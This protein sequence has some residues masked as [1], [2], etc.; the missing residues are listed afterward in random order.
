MI[1][2]ICRWHRLQREKQPPFPTCRSGCS[3]GTGGLWTYSCKPHCQ[4]W[5]ALP[6]EATQGVWQVVCECAV[7]QKAGEAGSLWV[8]WCEPVGGLC[9][10][11]LCA[12]HGGGWG[13][14]LG[15]IIKIMESYSIL[16]WKGPTKVTEPNCCMEKEALGP[17]V[18]IAECSIH[19]AM[20]TKTQW[21]VLRFSMSLSSQSCL[22]CFR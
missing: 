11:H 12:L 16:S 6:Q 8:S 15:R 14:A 2:I 4:G 10:L 21:T 20:C 1:N 19:S 17:S 5:G 3:S 13:K 9:S 22:G 7:T 18:H